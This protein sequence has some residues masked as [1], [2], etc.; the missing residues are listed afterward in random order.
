MDSIPPK[1]GWGNMAL[2]YHDVFWFVYRT[3]HMEKWPKKHQVIYNDGFVV[4][5]LIGN[6]TSKL[7]LELRIPK[8]TMRDNHLSIKV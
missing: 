2:K 3:K 6:D 1:G 4:P 5:F 7:K 8:Y